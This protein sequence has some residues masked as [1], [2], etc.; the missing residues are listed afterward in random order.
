MMRREY[1]VVIEPLS[2]EDGGGF[3]TTV[4]DLPG[5]MSD[6]ETREEAAR[7]IADAIDA[8]IEE[9]KRLG[10]PIPGPSAHLAMAGE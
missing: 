2:H 9:A 10:R 8:W 5:C 7:S 4:P 3:L 1:S 6:G